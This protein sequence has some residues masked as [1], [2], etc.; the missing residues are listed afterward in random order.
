MDQIKQPPSQN[1]TS[2][3]EGIS[4]LQTL[5]IIFI[6]IFSIMLASNIYLSQSVKE[7]AS[8]INLAGRQ[9][10][11]SQRL[12]KSIS[13]MQV[14]I[15]END[16][17]AGMKAQAEVLLSYNLF[18]DTLIAFLESGKTV[19]ASGDKVY[20]KAVKKPNTRPHAAETLIIWEKISQD[21]NY[22][23]TTDLEKINIDRLD[24][25]SDYLA[26]NNLKLLKSMNSLTVGL[27][28]NS[29]QT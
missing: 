20:I 4:K 26:Q 3:S 15:S 28:M 10:M 1:I 21:L 29:Q 9:R 7:D 17:S 2:T 23:A 5:G 22:V 18:N 12:T 19:G 8:D 16:I 25:V 11:L 27:D 14:S 24:E 13:N 6:I